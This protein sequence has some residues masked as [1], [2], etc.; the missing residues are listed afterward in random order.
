M[1]NRWRPK[2]KDD[3]F[4]VAR[5]NTHTGDT[6]FDPDIFKTKPDAIEYVKRMQERLTSIGWTPY[7]T[8][9]IYKPMLVDEIKMDLSARSN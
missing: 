2:Y 8:F 7:M 9:V 4:M 5:V 6:V 1:M 3:F